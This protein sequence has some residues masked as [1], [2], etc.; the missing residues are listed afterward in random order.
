MYTVRDVLGMYDI[1]YK[2]EHTRR[3]VCYMLQCW[4]HM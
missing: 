3:Y 4:T 2:F 1:C